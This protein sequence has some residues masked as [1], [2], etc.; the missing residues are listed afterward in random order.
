[1]LFS[2]GYC[3]KLRINLPV[4][5]N[6]LHTSNPRQ[7]EWHLRPL[8]L[9]LKSPVPSDIEISR[10]QTPKDINILAQEIG[11]TDDEYS[12]YG[13]TK[14]KINLN[15]V[16]RLK[17]TPNGKYVL[18]VGITPTPLGEGK[19]TTTLGLVQALSAHRD[20]NSF[21]C[22]RQ[23]SQGPTFGIKGGAAGGGY[24]QVIPMEDFNLHLT[25][26]IHA[27]TAANNLLA[28]QIDARILHETSQ[29]DKSLYDRLVPTV[30]G[31][32][33]FSKIQLKR[34]QKLGISKTDPDSLTPEEAGR[35]SRL[36]IDPKTV[37]W[38][39]VVDIND[40]FLRKIT[41]GQSPTEKGLHR[42]TAFDISVA[43]EVMAILALSTNL[44]DMKE[45][46]G[47]IVVGFSRK[48][49]AVTAEDLGMTGAMAI[50]LKDAIQPT[51][52]QSLEGSPVLV[53]AGPFAN[54]AHGCSSIVA[55]A[56][57][58]KLVGKDGYVVTEAGFGSDI[59]MEKFLNIKCRISNF[60]PNVV[61]L[62]ATIRALKM[63]GGGPKV[64]PGS[65]L[66]KEYV[67]ENLTLL[68]KGLPNLVKHIENAKR[69]NLPVI[70]AI[71]SFVTDSD[72]ECTL[73][74][75]ISLQNGAFRA[76]T[77]THWEHGGQ[78]AEE[79]ADAV[80]EACQERNEFQFLYDL[81]L[82]IEEKVKKI[83]KEIY[84]AGS[85]EFVPKV[86]VLMS[87]YEKYGYDKLPVCMAKT[88]LSL[89]GDPKLKGVPKD[90]T[91]TINDMFVSAGA[92]FVVPMVGEITKMPGLSTRPS[93]Y[94]MDLDTETEEIQG[95]F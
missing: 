47:K 51:L 80:I 41:V 2:V 17:D 69:F 9:N 50:L 83:A 37:T 87:D 26:D 27:V 52:M 39:R 76:V 15:V 71:N 11:L 62:V 29:S 79:L 93:V 49:E 19:S 45:R 85:V 14:A 56:V 42:E 81:S 43:S 16:K 78:G 46:L 55:D 23:P 88:A 75:N 3:L 12:L 95:L 48:G 90:F 34:L 6:F 84:G 4:F 18:V 31:K 24:S 20:K 40:R 64:T 21:A 74:K 65:P 89:S 92:G 70:V 60:L 35:F 63:H 91:L 82:P 67:E 7:N 61:V 59:G 77:C 53:H 13:K 1:M 86:K 25:G 8:P 32:R 33:Q 30:R 68:E 57:A 38:R 66:A 36:D 54:I 28:A 58:L 22:I 72:R 44:A 73:V 5:R 94:D 10:A